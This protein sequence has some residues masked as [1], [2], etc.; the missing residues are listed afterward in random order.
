MALHAEANMMPF[1][2]RAPKSE[3]VVRE[4]VLP[5]GLPPDPAGKASATREEGRESGAKDLSR[6]S[7]VRDGMDRLKGQFLAS[8]NHELR[9][10]LSGVLGMTDLLLETNLD[11]E[12]RDYVETTRQCATQLL[13][14]LN[15]VLSYSSL[16]AG[17]LDTDTSEFHLVQLLHT[18]AGEIREKAVAKGLIFNCEFDDSLPE[19][20]HGDARQFREVISHLLHNAVKFTERGMVVLRARAVPSASGGTRLRVEVSDTGIGM[21]PE[22]LSQI[23]ESFRQLDS[24]FARSHHGLGL[25]LAIV[26]KLIH[27]MGGE[28]TVQ[29]AVGKGSTFVAQFPLAETPVDTLRPVVEITLPRRAEPRPGRKRVLIIEDN[30]IAQQILARLLSRNDFDFEIADSGK[31]GVEAAARTRFD[32]ILMDLQMPGMNGF[33]AADAIRA[34]PEYAEVPII[35]VSANASPE[36]RQ[37]CDAHSFQALVPKPIDKRLLLNTICAQFG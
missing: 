30:V 2:L 27:L 13:E 8:L 19:T 35:A 21:A 24:G 18:L 28:I 20:M 37:A 14:T 33:Q 10:P 32:L 36:C 9:T 5:A 25:G 15:H 4:G 31:A 16:S 26:D 1:P 12:Q 11:S 3:G 29:S 6:D 17:R 23:F 7:A 22:K 34:N